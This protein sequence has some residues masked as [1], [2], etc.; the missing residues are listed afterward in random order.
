MECQ[1]CLCIVIDGVYYLYCSPG[2][3]CDCGRKSSGPDN[4]SIS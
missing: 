4:T 2:L 3:C 1:K